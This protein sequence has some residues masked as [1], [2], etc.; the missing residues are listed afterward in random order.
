VVVG[1]GAS[2]V[3]F[4]LTALNKGH[5]VLM[6]DVGR[7]KPPPVNPKDS[8]NALKANL[9]DP[10]EYFLGKAYE[11]VLYPGNRGE[12]YGFPPSKNY[13]FETLPHIRHH[14]RG[15][16]PL[17]SFAQGGLGEAWTGGVYPFNDRELLDFPF[18]YKDIEP[19]YNEVARRIGIAG[20]R[21]DLTRYLPFHDHIMPPLRLD[22]H[23]ELLLSTYKKNKEYFADRLE[24]YLGRSRIATHSR[25]LDSRQGCGYLGRCLWGCPTESLYTPVITLRQCLAFSTF[26][27]VSGVHVR[28]FRF[29]SKREITH[30]VAA[31]IAGGTRLEFPVDKLVLAAGTLFSSNIFL[32]SILIQTGERVRLKGLMDNRQILVPFINLRMIGENYETESYQY[33]QLSM[34]FESE[35]NKQYVHCQITTLKTALVH[36]IVQSMPLDLRTSIF[37][38][39]NLRAALGLVNVNLHDWRRNENY[40][41]VEPGPDSTNSRLV[42]NYSSDPGEEVVIKKTI[43]KLKKALWKLGCVVAPGM[44]HVRPMGASVHYAGT[45]PM[46]T[47]RISLTTSP[48]GLSHDFNNLYFADGTTFPFLPAKNITFTLMANAIRVADCNF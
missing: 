38:F 34:G 44:I 24:C 6:L 40:L 7:Q 42:V 5:E 28:H 32:A 23:S 22:K 31:A 47:E 41:T 29:N 21:D 25:D 14:A 12:Y 27:Y 45:V 13:V 11:A 8:L 39:R 2:G 4:A 19:Y 10:V 35:K 15:F 37:L 16:E 3:H 33:H 48:H 20:E 30:V 1:S 9:N 18:T 46:S 17:F 43:K 26:K 36:P